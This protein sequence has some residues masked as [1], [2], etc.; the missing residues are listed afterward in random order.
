MLELNDIQGLVTSGYAHMPHSRYLFLQVTNRYE[1]KAWLK[2]L[3]PQIETSERRPKGSKKPETAVHVSFCAAG[4]RAMGIN[5]DSMKSFPREFFVGMGSLERGKVLGDTGASSAPNWQLGGPSTPIVHLL[6]SLYGSSEAHLEEITNQAGSLSTQSGLTEVF[7]QNSYKPNV[8]EPFG[9]RDGVSQ[10]AIE[11]V[12]DVVLP[13]QDVIKAGEFVLGYNN[14]YGQPGSSPSVASSFD[15]NQILPP[16]I[17]TPGRKDLGRNGSYLVFRKLA[18]D[19][20]GFWKFMEERTQN[21]DGSINQ[22]EKDKLAAKFVGRWKS[23]APLTLSPESDDKPLGKDELRNNK[24]NYMDTDAEGKGCPI[25]A[26]ARRANPRDTLKPDAPRSLEIARRHRIMRRGRPYLEKARTPGMT[27][28]DGNETGLL[29]MCINAD[30]QRQ[31]EFIQQTWINSP[32]FNGLYDNR[33]PLVGNTDD[34]ADDGSGQCPVADM[35]IG[36]GN[37]TIQAY[38]V[39]QR[40]E[41]IPRFVEVR[42]GGYFFLPGIKALHFLAE[43]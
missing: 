5:E 15:P 19:V 16:S 33:D 7:R 31:F 23:G 10:P 9:F 28:K 24:F 39:R 27:N 22:P 18:Q 6:L 43:L 35:G 20:E 12:H 21:P 41:G 17:D 42:G 13:G 34:T 38:P 26:H 4:L 1:V 29:F 37:M 2:N 11:G 3:T 25:G 40:V 32:K 14:E 8:Y 30:L 36:K